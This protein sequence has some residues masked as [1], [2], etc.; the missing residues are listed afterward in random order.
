MLANWRRVLTCIDILQ[1]HDQ[2]FAVT[3]VTRLRNFGA[4][5]LGAGTGYLAATYLFA[6]ET[7]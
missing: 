7:L 3:R 5:A 2:S 6:A 4:L 1:S